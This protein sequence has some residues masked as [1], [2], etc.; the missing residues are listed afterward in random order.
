MNELVKKKAS[1]QHS[2]SLNQ[3]G[4]RTSLFEHS[5]Y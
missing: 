3:G 2:D 4:V 5:G 1:K